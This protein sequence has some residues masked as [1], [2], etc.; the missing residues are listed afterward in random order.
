MTNIK[1]ADIGSEVK[2]IDTLKY[3][4]KSLRELA[5]ILTEEEIESVKKLTTQCLNKHYYKFGNT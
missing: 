1:F 2:F 4:Q 5:S 3:Y